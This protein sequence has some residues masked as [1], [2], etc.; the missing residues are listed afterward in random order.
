MLLYNSLNQYRLGI[1]ALHNLYSLEFENL[2][3]AVKIFVNTN[4]IILFLIMHI[5][6]KERDLI[7]SNRTPLHIAAITNS[8][9]MGELLISKGAEIR[10]EHLLFALE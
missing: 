7:K 6:I 2:L 9:R 8:F 1:S 4:L 5:Q 3:K 10:N